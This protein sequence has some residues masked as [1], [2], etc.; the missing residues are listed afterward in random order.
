[1]TEVVVV[2]GAVLI[3]VSFIRVS[4]PIKPL[5]VQYKLEYQEVLLQVQGHLL[6][7]VSARGVLRSL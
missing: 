6:L 3:Q 4:Q 1:M 5:Q 2:V 7:I